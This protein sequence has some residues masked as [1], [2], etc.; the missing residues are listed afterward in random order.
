MSIRNALFDR[1]DAFVV[2]WHARQTVRTET[3][4]EHHYFVA[5]DAELIARALHYYHIAEPLI[6]DVL[7]MAMVH[8]EPEK[9]TG[10]VSGEA[11]R[12]YPELKSV[13]AKIER[14]VI[15]NILFSGLPTPLGNYYRALAHRITD[16]AKDDL[17]AQIVKYADKLEA[18]LFAFTE[19]RQGNGLMVDVVSRITQELD[20]LTWEWLVELRRETGLP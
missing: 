17:E 2:R 14:G 19:V 9:E 20:G 11:K 4:A 12:L 5:R 15:D 16:P 3:L 6:P 10:D 13:L 7:M 8:D 18:Y 1:R